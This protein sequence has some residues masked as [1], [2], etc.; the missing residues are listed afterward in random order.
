MHQFINSI[1]RS[2]LNDLVV[3][4]RDDLTRQKHLEC[5][6][7]CLACSKEQVISVILKYQ[8]LDAALRLQANLPEQLSSLDSP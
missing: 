8:T 3:L 1:E 4:Y 7:G 6:D 5:E 2:L